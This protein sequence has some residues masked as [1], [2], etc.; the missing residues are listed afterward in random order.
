MQR[1]LLLGKFFLF[2][3]SRDIANCV[4]TRCLGHC[5]IVSRRYTRDNYFL[6]RYFSA[7]ETDQTVDL[8]HNIL[9][10]RLTLYV[11][12][13]NAISSFRNLTQKYMP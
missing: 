7:A 8:R 13:D 1:Y 9:L 2:C 6:Q 4:S 10:R 3:C 5:R 11:V 12:E